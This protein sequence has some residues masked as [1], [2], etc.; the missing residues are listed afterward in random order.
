MQG[1]T[2]SAGN[3]STIDFHDNYFKFCTFE[4]LSDG[5]CIDSDFHD[6]TFKNI[7]WYWALFNISSFVKCQFTDCIF[8]GCSFHDCLFVECTFTNCQFVKDNMGGD[9]GFEGAIAYGCKVENT[10]GFAITFA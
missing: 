7:D 3:F 2:I 8:R 10:V 5:G 6:C 1:E 9:C 4:G